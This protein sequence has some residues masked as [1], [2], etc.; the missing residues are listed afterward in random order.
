M[1]DAYQAA[2]NRR[3][4]E[5]MDATFHFPH[6]MIASG[7]VFTL[8]TPGY[9]LEGFF[10]RF[11]AETGWHYTRWDHVRA[12]QS[13]DDK[14]HFAV[15]YTRCRSDDSVITSYESLYVAALIDGRWGLQARSSFAPS[16]TGI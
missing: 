11:I 14:V 7:K 10:D 13:S 12:V 3:D 2:F 9:I 6:T 8:E 15:K 4:P 1:V 16:R 5:G